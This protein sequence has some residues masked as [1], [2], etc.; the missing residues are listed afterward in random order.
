VSSVHQ[1]AH[2]APVT[3]DGKSALD[4]HVIEQPVHF[5]AHASGEGSFAG[6]GS[7]HQLLGDVDGSVVVAHRDAH[8]LDL[9]AASSRDV[10]AFCGEVGTSVPVDVDGF[11]SFPTLPRRGVGLEEFEFR[12]FVVELGAEG[13]TVVL[14]EQRI[15]CRGVG[16]HR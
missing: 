6:A 3:P 12:G 16:W 8:V 2:A 5:E 9:L 15:Q 13:R 4:T 7:H 1:T 14:L 11:E 10:A